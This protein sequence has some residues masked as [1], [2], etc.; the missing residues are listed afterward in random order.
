[1][2][3]LGVMRTSQALRPHRVLTTGD[4]TATTSPPPLRRQAAHRRRPRQFERF[5]ATGTGDGRRQRRGR[6]KARTARCQRGAT[7]QRAAHRQRTGGH[8]RSKGIQGTPYKGH[9]TDTDF[10][11]ARC[12][13]R[14]D[15]GPNSHKGRKAMGRTVFAALGS[16]DAMA[17]AITSIHG[18]QSG[19]AS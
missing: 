15:S 4:A 5:T 7:G 1:M 17:V 2:S 8:A 9:Y 19:Y 13:N 16:D 10:R 11:F 3:L 18:S 14:L 6:R 12:A